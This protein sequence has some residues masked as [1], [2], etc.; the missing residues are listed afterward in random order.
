VAFRKEEQLPVASGSEIRD[1]IHSIGQVPG[2]TKKKEALY[3]RLLALMKA[4]RYKCFSGHYLTYHLTRK[5]QA[6]VYEVPQNQRGALREFAGRRVLL[7][8]AGGW[9]GYGGRI[10]YAGIA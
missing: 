1:L 3:V 4:N 10:Y 8:C 7:V 2:W 9:D 6:C 5:G